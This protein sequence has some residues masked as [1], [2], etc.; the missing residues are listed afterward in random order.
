MKSLRLHPS[1]VPLPKPSDI[2]EINA[3]STLAMFRQD[4]WQWDALHTGR[5]TTSKLA[6][7]LGF[8]EGFTA[9]SLNIPRSL[10]SHSRVVSA[11]QQLRSR[12]PSNWNFL[13]EN[14]TKNGPKTKEETNPWMNKEESRD[15]YFEYTYRPS[16]LP[17]NER[18]SITSASA[19]RLAWGSAQEAT[20]I[21][22]ALNYF[23][24]VEPGTIVR[25]AGMFTFEALQE[26]MEHLSYLD[27]EAV[28]KDILSGKKGD[29]LS[30]SSYDL[31]KNV[32]SWI[33]GDKTLPL[34][35][36]SPDGILQH[37]DGRVEVLEVKCTSPF[38]E[39]MNK[40]NGDQQAEQGNSQPVESGRVCGKQALRVVKGY[41]RGTVGGLPVWHVPQLQLEMLCV[42]AH[43][44]SAVV[45]VL[46]IS[47]ARIYR[48]QRDDQVCFV[49]SVDLFS[50]LHLHFLQYIT[51]MMGFT[52]KFYCDHI[53]K[54]PTNRQKPPLPNFY[55]PRVNKKYAEFLQRTT[56]VAA[57]AS[58]IVELG[59][60][61]VQRSP[62]NTEFFL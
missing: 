1:F 10:Q 18:S 49:Y 19:A 57:S 12:P 29:A 44:R 38:I 22:A 47:G 40:K 51:D 39:G 61:E 11:W 24:M 23:V 58:I 7:C 2:L 53:G 52:R 46:C 32:S 28:L 41:G 33:F 62:Y 60:D 27:Q 30:I 25:E 20:A 59:E 14:G 16:F 55:N 5:L 35:G 43:C 36:A 26:S 31:Y 50:Q 3:Y 21:L 42:G 13:C 4:T 15:K 34:L 6:C 56:E 54:L 8:F 37:I 45:V 48:L 17:L 9:C